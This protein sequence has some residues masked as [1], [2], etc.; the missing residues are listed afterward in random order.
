MASEK[1]KAVTIRSLRPKEREYRVSDGRQLYLV[2]K[3]NGRKVWILQYSAGGRRRRMV[4]GEFG[5]PNE[6][7]RVSLAAARKKAAELRERI[8]AGDD[9]LEKEDGDSGVAEGVAMT[10]EKLYKDWMHV[11]R[12]RPDGTGWSQ[13]HWER[14]K[15]LGERYLFRKL[16]ARDPAGIERRE[17]AELIRP[18]WE[19]KPQTALKLLT[20]CS[21]AFR[22]G[23]AMGLAIDFDPCAG[24]RAA[25]PPLPRQ[26]H[27]AALTDPASVG[28]LMRAI[29]AY[30]HAA[31]V[32]DALHFHAW[33]A[34]RSS[35]VRFASWD[36][37]DLD[38]ALW[39]IPA[40]KM[41]ARREHR[42][43]LSRQ[44]VEMLRRRC[45]LTGPTGLVFPSVRSTARSIS[46][47]TVLMALR[48]MGY[49]KQVMT[50]HGFRGMF[51]TLVNASGKWPS[52]VIE[53]Q[54]AHA[55]GDAVRDAYNRTDYLDRRREMMQWW[56]D[57]L[58]ELRAQA[59][60]EAAVASA[61]PESTMKSDGGSSA[62]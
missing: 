33:T 37:I 58:D 14:N 54:L 59:D 48:S 19:S 61:S 5:E 2:V 35:E 9:P 8:A 11:H 21:L 39:T 22:H 45:E 42:C 1:L 25:M 7:G 13:E 30:P 27:F 62:S 36:E 32:R 51:S 24:V 41:K 17:I 55:S 47:A 50:T 43:P 60:S 4:L 49:E 15:Y 16:G 23:M 26:Q 56:A 52:D 53:A 12:P 20:S 10:F 31:V 57:W 38:T 6:P 44:A 28:R 18:V 3:P 40:E 29:H 34:A 46:E